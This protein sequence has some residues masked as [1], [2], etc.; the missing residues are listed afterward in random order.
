MC[1]GGTNRIGY[2]CLPPEDPFIEF[3]TDLLG[4]ILWAYTF[5]MAYHYHSK[6]TVSKLL[7]CIDRAEFI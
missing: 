3:S 7:T 1:R 4:T 2:R 5:Y 6:V